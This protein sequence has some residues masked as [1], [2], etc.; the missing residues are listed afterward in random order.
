M[1]MIDK[2]YQMTGQ[3]GTPTVEE[4]EKVA[5]FRMK[6]VNNLISQMIEEARNGEGG[7]NLRGVLLSAVEHYAEGYADWMSGKVLNHYPMSKH[8]QRDMVLK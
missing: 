2:K 5:K 1:K 7:E 3:P 4:L 8:Q 6:I